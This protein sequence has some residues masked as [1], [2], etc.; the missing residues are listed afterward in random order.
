MDGQ[1][2][3]S[4]LR[5]FRGIQDPRAANARHELSN[6]LGIAILAV[7]CGSD[8]WEAV[9]AWGRGNLHWL[10]TFLDLPHG[11][12]SHDTFDRVF[13][14][15]D[16]LAFEQRFMDWTA[17]LVGNSWFIHCRGWQDA[18]TEL[19]ARLEQDAGAYGQRVCDEE[20]VDAGTTG[21]RRQKQ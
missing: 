13:A 10:E 4:L 21:H 6:I 17:A 12:P 8:A 18:A 9:E 7:L 3:D 1:A 5:F 20:P 11:V 19:E 14:Q 15:L 16:P 2:T